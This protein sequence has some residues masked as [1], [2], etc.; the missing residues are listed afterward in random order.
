MKTKQTRQDFEFK[1]M[2]R[3]DNFEVLT[4]CAPKASHRL[5]EIISEGY[6]ADFPDDAA[7]E[8]WF[9]AIEKKESGKFPTRWRLQVIGSLNHIKMLL[10][11]HYKYRYEAYRSFMRKK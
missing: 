4:K 6:N 3:E 2:M 11:S 7:L 8:E 5:I 1:M 10:K 9:S